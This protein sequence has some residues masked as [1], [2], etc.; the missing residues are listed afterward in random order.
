MKKSRF[1]SELFSEQNITPTEGLVRYSYLQHIEQEEKTAQLAAQRLL[2]WY[3]RDR[4]AILDHLKEA[5]KKTFALD[6]VNAWQFPLINGVPRIIKRISMAYANAPERTLV[7]NGEDLKPGAKEYDLYAKMF[8]YIDIDKKMKE[9]DRYSTLLNTIHLEVVPRKDAI[10]WDFRLRPSVIVVPDP[11]DYLQ[12]LKLGY[13]WVPFDPETLITQEGWVYWDDES[14][15]F[16]Y[17]NTQDIG[18]SLNSG[19]NPYKGIIPIVTIRKI[20]Q[21]DYWGKYGADL[22]DAFEQAN[23]QL[24]NLWENG[25]LQTHGQPIATNLGIKTPGALKIGPRNPFVIEDLTI[26]DYKPTLEFVTPESRLDEARNLVDWFIKNTGNSYGLPQGAWSLDQTPESGFAKFMDNIELLENREDEI[27]QWIDIEQELF[28]KSVMVYNR[29][30]RE[31]NHEKF[32]E[33]LELKITFPS[34]SFPESPTEEA[35]RWTI[36]I[37]GGLRTSIDYYMQ[38]DGLT[39]EEALEK[40]KKVAEQKKMLSELSEPEMPKL[41]DDGI[42]KGKGGD[43]GKEEGNEFQKG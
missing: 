21:H 22:V 14:H 15:I 1:I 37:S 30:A 42:Q 39:E 8:Q 16:V 3:L 26:D 5:A 17:S 40:A 41:P 34:I 11:E 32:P 25:F 2:D 38:T 43:A 10:D 28:K 18:M 24:A 27:Q 7:K 31:Q 20:E 12:F 9:A 23:L 13:R 6:E 36:L 29:W 4:E 35:T 33:D 19:L